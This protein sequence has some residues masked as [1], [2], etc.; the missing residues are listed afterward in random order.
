MYI[1]AKKDLQIR[2]NRIFKDGP[3]EIETMIINITDYYN[4]NE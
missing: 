3:F 4:A 2:L 1:Y